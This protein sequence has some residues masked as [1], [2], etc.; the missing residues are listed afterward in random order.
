MKQGWLELTVVMWR[1]IL[2][3]SLVKFEIFH[4]KKLK[5]RRKAGRQEGSEGKKGKDFAQAPF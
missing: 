5:E 1:F 2:L 3:C 4:N